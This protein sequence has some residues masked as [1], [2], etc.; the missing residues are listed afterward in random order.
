LKGAVD[1]GTAASLRSQ[2]GLKNDIAGKTGTTQSNSDGWFMALTPELVVGTWVGAD[3]PS[4]RFRTTALGQGAHMAL[5]IFARLYQKA[6]ADNSLSHYTRKKFEPL[7]ARESRLLSCDFFKDD[8]NF[9]EKLFGKNEAEVKE[10]K[11]GEK[12]K[13]K[14]FFKRLFGG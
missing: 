1:S 12:E 9:V 6:N 2:Y 3:D 14:G 7:N 10:K 5:P 4:I 13:K 8:A 11:F